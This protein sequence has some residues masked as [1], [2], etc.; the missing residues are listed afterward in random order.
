MDA[1]VVN[2][3]GGK[4]TQNNRQMVLK[5]AES[6]NREEA[7]KLVGRKV[8]WNTPSG[9]KL[10]GEITRPHGNKGAV[11]AAFEKGLPGQA[12]GMK[13]TII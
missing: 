3:R 11:I 2:Y 4:R 7:A 13:A 5:P 9:K 10:S 8:E 12:L 1:V 6:N